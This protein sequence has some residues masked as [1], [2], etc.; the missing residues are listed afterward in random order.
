MANK[1]R[2]TIPEDNATLSKYSVSPNDLD[3]AILYRTW[4]GLSLES[5]TTFKT[6]LDATTEVTNPLVDHVAWPGTYRT[7]N[8]IEKVDSGPLAGSCR[9][10]QT[11]MKGFYSSATSVNERITRVRSYP[12]EQR[13]NTWMYYERQITEETKKWSNMSYAA[14]VTEYEFYKK[15][16]YVDGGTGIGG[17]WGGST[18]DSTHARENTLIYNVSNAGVTIYLTNRDPAGEYSGS[19]NSNTYYRIDASLVGGLYL[20]TFTVLTS[21]IISECWYEAERDGSY[22][23][24]RTIKTTEHDAITR[25]KTLQYAGLVTV[26]GYPLEDDAIIVLGG[27]N[28]ENEILYKHA[29]FIIDGDSTKYRVTADATAVSGNV[30]VAITP[31]ITAATELVVDDGEENQVQVYFDAL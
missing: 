28:N 14:V 10:V 20:A 9:V 1:Y 5:A 7:V 2:T 6:T 13:E 27:F 17:T 15:I 19:L 26:Q 21:P 24:Y 30:T 12:E 18:L 29:K 31:P 23:L 25:Y 22:S 3:A 16:Y 4:E 8:E 11:L